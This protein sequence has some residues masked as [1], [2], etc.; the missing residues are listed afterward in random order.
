M[1]T[2]PIAQPAAQPIGQP[3]PTATT[4]P[5]PYAYSTG[6]AFAAF[7][8]FNGKNYFTWRRNMQTQLKALGQWEVVDGSVTAP[9]IA[10][11]GNPTPDEEL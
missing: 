1:S 3:T 4:E 10:T 5:L 11:P 9:A 7:A 2:Q 6:N 8:K